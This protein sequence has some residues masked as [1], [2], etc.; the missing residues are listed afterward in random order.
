[1][2]N[3]IRWILIAGLLLF[4]T[5]PAHAQESCDAKPRWLL[6]TV[7]ET[8]WYARSEDDDGKF[9]RKG[10]PLSGKTPDGSLNMIDRC[11]GTVLMSINPSP[12][13]KPG[14]TLLTVLH[15]EGPRPSGQIQYWVKESLQD[16]CRAMKDCGDATKATKAE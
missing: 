15:Y 2:T 4:A 11:S 12:E 5:L 14:K 8:D 6:V 1:M 7:L 16:L 3:P 13:S 9:D 10:Y